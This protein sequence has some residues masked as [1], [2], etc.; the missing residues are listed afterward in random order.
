MILKFKVYEKTISL[1]ATK[2]GTVTD[3]ETVML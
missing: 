2:A 3:D 1:Q